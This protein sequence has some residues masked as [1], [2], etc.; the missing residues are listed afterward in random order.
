M[1]DGAL[2]VLLPIDPPKLSPGAARILLEIVLEAVEDLDGKS[3]STVTIT[4]MPLGEEVA[5]R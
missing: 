1:T 5:K 2:A 4:R 3:E